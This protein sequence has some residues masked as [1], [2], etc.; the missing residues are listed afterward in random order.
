MGFDAHKSGF[1]LSAVKV[2]R[3][4]GTDSESEIFAV[5]TVLGR[6]KEVADLIC[7]QATYRGLPVKAIVVSPETD[8]YIYVEAPDVTDVL[9]ATENVRTA[10][11]VIGRPASSEDVK[12]LLN[13][14]PLVA[15]VS[16]GDAVE[17][18]K[19]E[20]AGERGR[21]TGVSHSEDEATV[22][23][24]TSVVPV[25]VTVGVGSVRRL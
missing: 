20:F 18:T 7:G 21:I 15:R 16:Y 12:R 14:R 8:G 2:S 6:E 17:I 22:E 13:P 4:Q 5:K 1:F 25:S 9:Q 10:R 19:G 3:T 24:D 11:K 23:L